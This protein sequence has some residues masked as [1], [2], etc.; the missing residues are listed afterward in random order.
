MVFCL[1]RVC[2]N[3][4]PATAGGVFHLVESGELRVES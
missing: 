4:G 2:F 1:Q 3:L